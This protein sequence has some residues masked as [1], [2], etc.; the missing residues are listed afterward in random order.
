MKGHIRV[1]SPKLTGLD[2]LGTQIPLTRLTGFVTLK[3]DYI[4]LDRMNARCW[5][6]TV[7]AAVKVGISDSAPAFDGEVK[8]QNMNLKN[9]AK[10]YGTDLEPALCEA[11]IRFRSPSSNINDIKAYG[12]GRI[13]NGDLLSLSIFRP[14]GAFVSDVTGN[15]KELD[16]SVRKHKTDSVLRRLSQT[17]GSTINAI[18]NQLDHTAQYIP[19]YNHVFAYDLQNAFID[20]VIDKGHFKTSK[21]KALGYNLKVTGDLDINL[22]TLEIY[23]NMWPQVSSLPT[24]LLSPITFLSD[25]MLDIV[26]F[27][28]VDDLQ[29]EFRLDPR[30]SSNSPKTANSAP[31]AEC[32]SAPKKS[33]KKKR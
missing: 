2:F 20:F 24:L 1:Q 11:N 23:G 3:D 30:V 33:A 25:F 9:I 4:Y 21:F 28:K 15:I 16:E 19:G 5:E 27:G 22:N 31:D 10:A 6:G 14:I 32:P 26:I 29:W 17:T 13:V 18:G 8:A 12:S 7:N